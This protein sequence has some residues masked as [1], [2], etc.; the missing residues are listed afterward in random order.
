MTIVELPR[1]MEAIPVI[2]AIHRRHQG[3]L[4]GFPSIEKFQSHDH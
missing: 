1:A 2:A 4:S 3:A